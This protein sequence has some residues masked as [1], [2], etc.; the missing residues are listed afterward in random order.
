M[1]EHRIH[2]TR[3]KFGLWAVFGGFSWG[4]R[5][6]RFKSIQGRIR[7]LQRLVW[8]AVFCLLWGM[9]PGGIA[10]AEGNLTNDGKSMDDPYGICEEIPPSFEGVEYYD[11]AIPYDMTHREIGGYAVKVL[12]VNPDKPYLSWGSV[13]P[14]SRKDTFV[15]VYVNYENAYEQPCFN[16]AG[17]RAEKEPDTGCFRL[18]KDGVYFYETA[19]QMFFLRGLKDENGNP[20]GYFPA[21][22]RGQIIDLILTD[23]TVIHFVLS[24]INSIHHTNCGPPEGKLW[25]VIWEFA[26]TDYPQ[27]SNIVSALAGNCIELRGDKSACC[28]AFAEKYNIGNGEGQNRIAYYR[29]YNASITDGNTKLVTTSSAAKEIA[30]NVSDV[31]DAFMKKPGGSS[32]YGPQSGLISEEDL[33]GMPKPGKDNHRIPS[34]ENRDA[35]ALM[36]QY[37]VATITEALALQT[38]IEHQESIRVGISFFG[39]ALSVWSMIVISGIIL[40]RANTLFDISFVRLF[41]FGIV[42]HN[43]YTGE[44]VKS[45]SLKIVVSMGIVLAVGLF[46]ISGSVFRFMSWIVVGLS[47][48]F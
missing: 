24:D 29:M 43:P 27:Y 10:R 3:L 30:Y 34:L 37:K 36:E 15:G 12:D 7:G 38:E 26:P 11:C 19:V 41:T 42:N 14:E 33:L 47:K 17:V 22:H 21:S 45:N 28:R 35:L 1:G 18:V 23:G 25:E 46:L 31:G 5:F 4:C 48:I 39:I 13:M 32:S 9:L 40:D 6:R 2:R 20:C 44:G 8:V 16:D